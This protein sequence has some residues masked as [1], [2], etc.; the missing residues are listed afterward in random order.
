MKNLYTARVHVT[1]G[2]DGQ[3]TSSDG[4]LA[5]KLGFPKEL[6]GAG[7]AANPEQLFVAGYAACFASTVRSLAN[8]RSIPTG[9]IEIDAEGTL[10]IRE[11]GTYLIS[12]VHLAVRA[13][14][15]GEA[16]GALI[17]EAQRYC[18]Y[19]NATRGNVAT[20]VQLV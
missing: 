5:L 9:P 12:T 13:P 17:Q 2:R 15:L 6:G 4:R 10:S 19:S 3:A 16:G 14:D 20:T 18:A 11:D 8:A 1:G 7:D